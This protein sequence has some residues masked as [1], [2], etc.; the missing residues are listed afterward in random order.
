[1]GGA[2]S[3]M[4]STIYMNRMERERLVSL[5]PKFYKR[6]ARNIKYQKYR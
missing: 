2:I 4:M 6:Y 3:V 5:K 1:M